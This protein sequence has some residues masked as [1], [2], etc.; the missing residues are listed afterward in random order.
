MSFWRNKALI[1]SKLQEAFSETLHSSSLMPAFFGARF[2][3]FFCEQDQAEHL[4]DFGEHIADDLAP[5]TVRIHMAVERQDAEE[6]CAEKN[7]ER[8]FL[9]ET[10]CRRA[11]GIR[12]LA[13]LQ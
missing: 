8:M 5:T 12:A 9:K 6:K 2:N 7:R 11:G 13:A 1:V 3:E 10:A 4:R